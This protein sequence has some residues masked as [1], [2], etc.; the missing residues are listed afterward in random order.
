[1]S[2]STGTVT[3]VWPLRTL[4]KD[5]GVGVV[6]AVALLLG[7]LLRTQALGTR[8][9]NSADT[10]FGISYP[11]NWR[12]VTGN[13]GA[14]LNIEDPLA[15]SAYKTNVTIQ[16]RELDPSSPPTL[17]ELVDRRIVEN[18]SLLGYHL[19]DSTETNVAGS[20]AMQ[21]EYAYVVQP[22]DTPRSASTPVVVHCREYVVVAGNRTYYMTL[23]A[24]E[25]DFS[26]ASGQFD[27]MIG[28]AKLQ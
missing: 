23:A 25:S 26:K 20:R 7:L 5:V 3:K 1:M 12:T 11:A 18:G 10:G 6:V 19:L 8:T 2:Q 15:N 21:L 13:D 16:S 22:I 9:F 24:P 17:Q 28:T 4:P 27:R 14:L